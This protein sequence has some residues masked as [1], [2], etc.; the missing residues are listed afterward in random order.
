MSYP[1]TQSGILC[2]CTHFL[3]KYSHFIAQKQLL[4]ELVWEYTGANTFSLSNHGSA[5]VKF[6]PF[7]FF[8][9]L[10]PFESDMLYN[11][12]IFSCIAHPL[13]FN[14]VLPCLGY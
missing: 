5:F 9:S 10:N 6:A 4:F 14:G 13:I 7:S 3:L 12:I 1:E 11:H 8:F 2:V